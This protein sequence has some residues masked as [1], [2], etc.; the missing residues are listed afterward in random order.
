[1]NAKHI[2]LKPYMGDSGMFPELDALRGIDL[3]RRNGKFLFEKSGSGG[4]GAFCGGQEIPIGCVCGRLHIAGFSFWGG[5]AGNVELC[6]RGEAEKE[7]VELYFW[8]WCNPYR[9][10]EQ[11]YE[12]DFKRAKE[13]PRVLFMYDISGGKACVYHKTYRFPKHRFL[14][15]IKLPDNYFLVIQAVTAEQ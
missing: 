15:S 5:H 11:I 9:H 3:S 12:D 8:D 4:Y 2:D 14:E 7:S 13:M 1:M 10:S 6:F